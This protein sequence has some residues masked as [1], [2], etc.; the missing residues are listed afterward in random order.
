M[1]SLKSF[2]DTTIHVGHSIITISISTELIVDYG[3]RVVVSIAGLDSIRSVS[4]I[5][6]GTNLEG[7]RVVNIRVLVS[8]NHSNRAFRF[9]STELSICIGRILL[10]DL[11][12]VNI[13]VNHLLITLGLTHGF[14][15]SFF[16]NRGRGRQIGGSTIL[17]ISLNHG[18]N[19]NV[20]VSD[21]ST[22]LRISIA[23]LS[24]RNSSKGS[25]FNIVRVLSNNLRLARV[26]SIGG[27]LYVLVTALR[28]GVDNKLG[29]STERSSRLVISNLLVLNR[30]SKNLRVMLSG[31]IQ[32]NLGLG[33][34]L[35][36]LDS[37][38]SSGLLLNIFNLLRLSTSIRNINTTLVRL[39]I[40]N[41]HR[42]RLLLDD[43][44]G[45]LL[46]LLIMIEELIF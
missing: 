20:T 42:S 27:S 36:I 16:I 14:L 12:R 7:S 11:V 25:F 33:S 13:L 5:S 1:S 31:T 43:L 26:I 45:L 4:S 28:L 2:A 46:N 22:S 8:T 38:N 3:V 35:N 29:S 21:F 41:V 19:L 24:T 34:R 39:F 10:L 6:G 30:L 18:V 37:A 17:N 9:M 15:D 44:L 40:N 32:N 23:D